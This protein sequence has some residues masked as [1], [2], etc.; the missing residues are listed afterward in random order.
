M[1]QP[2]ES[3]PRDGTFVLLTDANCDPCHLIAQWK[4]DRWWGQRTNSGKA[5]IWTVATHWMPLPTP[6][7]TN[8]RD[9]PND[10]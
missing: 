9:S 1:W 6:P 10:H 8:L 5:I 3:A 7:C 2:I 4:V